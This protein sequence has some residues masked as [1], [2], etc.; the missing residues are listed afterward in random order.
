MLFEFTVLSFFAYFLW[1]RNRKREYLHNNK[2]RY[3]DVYEIADYF[4]AIINQYFPMA[5]N[6]IYATIF[7]Y[8]ELSVIQKMGVKVF[9]WMCYLKKLN[10][11]T[12]L[13]YGIFSKY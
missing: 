10:S 7:K 6:N 4:Q 3:G 1:I 2:A 5:R 11:F 9:A 12:R 13:V 8:H